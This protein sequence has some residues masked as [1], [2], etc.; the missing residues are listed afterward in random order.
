MRRRCFVE[1]TTRL[2]LPAFG[3][4]AGSLNVLDPAFD[5]VFEAG[6]FNAWMIGTNTIAGLSAHQLSPDRG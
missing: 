3:A 4:L 6:H 2:I 1:D 5:T